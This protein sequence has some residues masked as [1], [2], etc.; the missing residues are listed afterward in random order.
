MK[1]ITYIA[2]LT[3]NERGQIES[4]LKPTKFEID[5]MIVGGMC[6]AKNYIPTDESMTTKVFMG[7]N[8]HSKE[9]VPQ[10]ETLE[11]ANEYYEKQKNEALLT[12]ER[13]RQTLSITENELS[14]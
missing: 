4:N 1:E 8:E 9:R 5:K 14:L 12:I 2:S 13:M 7:K 10:F 3:L 11:S 6:V